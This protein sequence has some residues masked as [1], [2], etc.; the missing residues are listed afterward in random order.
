MPDINICTGY[1]FSLIISFVLLPLFVASFR[2]LLAFLTIK[3]KIPKLSLMSIK[4]VFLPL[5]YANVIDVYY[6]IYIAVNK[7]K[8]LHMEY[9]V[10][11][12]IFRQ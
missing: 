12:S 7:E 11:N 5:R 4:C 1:F 8:K 3:K 10:E 2:I 9:R 6:K